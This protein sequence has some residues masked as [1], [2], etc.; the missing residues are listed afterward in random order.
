M[1]IAAV[2]SFK[3][4]GTRNKSSSS[5]SIEMDHREL[6]GPRRSI[7]LPSPSPRSILANQVTIV[8]IEYQLTN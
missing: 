3:L 5:V 6:R 7:A 1:S 4:D 2:E 8:V